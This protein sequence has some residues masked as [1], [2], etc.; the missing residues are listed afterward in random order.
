[1]AKQRQFRPAF[2]LPPGAQPGYSDRDF[3]L[4]NLND[5]IRTLA[6]QVDTMA[7]ADLTLNGIT[8]TVKQAKIAASASGDT[9]VVAAVTGKKIRVIALV[10]SCAGAVTV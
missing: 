1:M 7:S 8:Y 10:F 9:P 2:L 3:V 5:Y 4:K 6:D